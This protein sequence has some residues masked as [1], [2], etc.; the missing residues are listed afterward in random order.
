MTLKT[1]KKIGLKKFSI[2]DR[3]PLT[4]A[5]GV[6]LAAGA[7]TVA[8]VYWGAQASR[9]VASAQASQRVMQAFETVK[10]DTRDVEASYYVELQKTLMSKF[11]GIEVKTD[12]TT[13]TLEVKAAENYAVF[14][15][16]LGFVAALGGVV[17]YEATELCT[18][19]SMCV[20]VS[21]R[22]VIKGKAWGVS[23]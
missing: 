19:E 2:I 9:E 6:W 5:L 10:L 4:A 18:G 13:L 3:S 8:G 23:P 14:E 21:Y 11:A 15:Q 7:V 17:R 1:K 16:A 12:A 20:G 22:A